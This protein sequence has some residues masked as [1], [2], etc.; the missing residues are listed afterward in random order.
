[1]DIGII[2]SGMIGGTLARRFAAAGHRVT[3][4]NS[5]GPE[6][7]AGLVAEIGDQ[8]HAATT[9][10]AAAAGPVVVVAIPMGRYRELPAHQL[11]GKVVVDANNYYPGRDGSIPEL[12]AN[13]ITSSELLAAS[14]DGARVVKAFNTIYFEHLRDQGTPAGTPGRRALPIAG[15]DPQAKRT[16]ASLIDDLGFD[17]VDVGALADGRRQGPGTPVYNIALTRDELLAVLD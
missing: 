6:S 1:M 4:A 17:V 5:R 13:T 3:I 14:L 2:G 12:D 7:L 15:D 11:A 10:G 8:A 9:D 16:V